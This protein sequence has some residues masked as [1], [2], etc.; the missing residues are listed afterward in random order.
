M[1]KGRRRAL[2][3]SLIGLTVALGCSGTASHPSE[4]RA[5]APPPVRIEPALAVTGTKLAIANDR[6]GADLYGR[7]VTDPTLAGKDI[8][9][10]PISAATALQMVFIAARA[11]TATELG[12][13]LRLKG[14]TPSEIA[15]TASVLHRTLA[16]MDSAKGATVQRCDVLWPDT[17]LRVNSAYL[18]AVATAF[19]ARPRP[20]DY[21]G[22]PERAR[23]TI[24]D[25]VS[26]AT[27]GKIPQLMSPGSISGDTVMTLTDAIYLKADWQ[28]PFP[29]YRTATADFHGLD[30]R[31]TARMMTQQARLGYR[32][33]DGITA[34]TLPYRG[35]RLAMT[36]FLPTQRG[37]EAFTGLERTIA[38]SG[39]NSLLPHR[40][41]LVSLAMPKFTSRT[42]IDLKPA[43][44]AMGVR[45]AFAGGDFSGMSAAA[46][47]A[48]ST[49]VQQAYIAVG[50]KGTEAAAATGIAI[51]LSRIEPTGVEVTFDRPFVY[52]IT[53]RTS[54]SVLFLGRVL[55]PTG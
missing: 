25:A 31:S 21:A 30:G 19:G 2:A 9:Y 51:T 28:T 39:V 29:A 55:H 48:I 10:S 38:R 15:S 6:F 37:Q 26:R 8:V 53:D 33:A 24:N 12:A 42:T 7:L 20:L 34:V 27:H 45:R 52:A 43:L 17:G 18:D 49:V 1:G 40:S 54:A 3:A 11:S 50:E 22:D 5:P 44:Q 35:S 46:N 47:G 23:R 36:L 16:A 32:R 41:R 13:A 14:L 4:R